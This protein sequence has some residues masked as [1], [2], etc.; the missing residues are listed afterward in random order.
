MV[1]W[2]LLW[3]RSATPLYSTFPSSRRKSSTPKIPAPESDPTAL[4]ATCIAAS[5]MSGATCAGETTVWQMLS[6]CVVSTTG[7]EQIHAFLPRDTI[8]AN[9]FTKGAH[10]STYNINA[11]YVEPQWQRGE[12][13]LIWLLRSLAHRKRDACSSA[14]G[15][16]KYL[17]CFHSST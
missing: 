3:G 14:W 8:T 7:K 13:L 17:P 16:P 2:P 6:L 5:A 9:S 4:S 15:V 11:S 1:W 12:P 10:S